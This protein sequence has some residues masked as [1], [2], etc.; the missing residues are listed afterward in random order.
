MND[1]PSGASRM[2]AGPRTTIDQP[3]GAT[4]VLPAT[5]VFGE[6]AA[7]RSGAC[8]A[9]VA[10][11]A[12]P[13]P[14]TDATTRVTRNLDVRMINSGP[15]ATR[16]TVR[17]SAGRGSS[18]RS[19]PCA[20][21]LRSVREHEQVQAGEQQQGEREQ[22]RVGHP[23]GS[24]PLRHGGEVR[25]DGQRKRDGQPAVRLPN[26]MVPVHRILASRSTSLPP[27]IFQP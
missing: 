26:P 14:T 1:P 15:E 20:A 6:S 18:C 27:I 11:S 13:S 25:D 2:V 9:A 5:V 8:A 22:R 7:M 21:P 23:G 17:T 4:N 10:A 12:L 24:L 16:G 19:L 3:A